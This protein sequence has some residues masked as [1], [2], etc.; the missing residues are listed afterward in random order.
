MKIFRIFRP[1]FFSNFLLKFVDKT[2]RIA[3]SSFFIQPNIFFKRSFKKYIFFFWDV[4]SEKFWKF[5]SILVQ[6]FSNLLFWNHQMKILRI[7]PL[8]FFKYVLVL[9]LRSGLYQ[10]SASQAWLWWLDLA[11]ISS[12][13]CWLEL[14]W[15]DLKPTLA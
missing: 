13:V 7:P 10:A 8:T 4:L 5:S 14:A 2:R 15:L 6:N 12:Q 3:T 1:K 11:L 9:F